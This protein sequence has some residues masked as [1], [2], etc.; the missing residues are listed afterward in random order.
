LDVTATLLLA[1][2]V[3]LSND[4]SLLSCNPWGKVTGN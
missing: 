2:N 4:C 1:T 3:S